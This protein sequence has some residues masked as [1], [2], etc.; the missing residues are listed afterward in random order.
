MADISD[1]G[2]REAIR[3]WIEQQHAELD[4]S[5]YYHLLGVPRSAHEPQIRD[6]Y[7]RLVARLHPDLYVNTLDMA[8]RQKLIT[9][10]S[11]VV[12]GYRILADGAK[13]V[14]YDRLLAEGKLRWSTED[15]RAPRRDPEAELKN[16][17]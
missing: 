14:Q 15:E 8:T 6:A 17:N 4:R 9:L 16:P 11:R 5:S 7:Y 10:Y 1:Q 2:A 13:R 12:E 3:A